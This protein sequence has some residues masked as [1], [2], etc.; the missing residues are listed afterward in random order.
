MNLTPRGVAGVVYPITAEEADRVM[1]AA[2]V[3]EFPGSPI[4]AVALPNKGYVVTIAYLLDSHRISLVA[5]PSA[6]IDASGA[7][8]PGF[9]F[10]VSHQGTMG[11]TAPPRA[12]SVFRRVTELAGLVRGPLREA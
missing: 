7:R 2:M 11:I 1:A 10:E 3:G 4:S 8:V 9:A 6:G 5:I 12:N